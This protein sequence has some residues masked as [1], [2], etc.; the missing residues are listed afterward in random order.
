MGRVIFNRF[1][2]ATMLNHTFNYKGHKIEIR[3]LANI[4]SADDEYEKYSVVEFPED[5]PDLA[6]KICSDG[7]ELYE[8]EDDEDTLFKTIYNIVEK[9][10]I[11]KISPNKTDLTNEDFIR[12]KRLL[13]KSPYAELKIS[14]K[15]AS[16]LNPKN[17]DRI[18]ELFS[19]E[20]NKRDLIVNKK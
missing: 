5:E 9:I 1:E 12:I 19:K 3:G 14:L 8:N 10:L 13:K 17:K 2:I 11:S 7:I 16:A 15:T 20:I 4:T 18:K 6:L